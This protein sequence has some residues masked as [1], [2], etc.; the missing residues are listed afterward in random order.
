MSSASPSAAHAAQFATALSATRIGDLL[1][2]SRPV[3]TA[4]GTLITV[5]LTWALTLFVTRKRIAWRI[6]TDDEFRLD[7]ERRDRPG[8]GLV[9]PHGHPGLR[10]RPSR[11]GETRWRHDPRGGALRAGRLLARAR[12][13]AGRGPEGKRRPGN[14]RKKVSKIIA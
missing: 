13:S 6:Y 12:E 4:G 1:E 8:T 10:R 3:Q 5:L 7:P 14:D 11:G 9:Q 2:H